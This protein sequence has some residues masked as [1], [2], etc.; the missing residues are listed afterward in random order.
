VSRYIAPAEGISQ[1]WIAVLEAMNAEAN[2]TATNVMVTI[3]SPNAVDV[4][5]VRQVLDEELRRRGQHEVATVANTL[6]PSTF[7]QPPAHDWQP[8]LPSTGIAELDDAADQLYAEYLDILPILRR[9]PANARGTYFSRMISWPGKT[10]TGTNQLKDRIEFLRK[11][12]TN[13]RATSNASD[14]VIAGDGEYPIDGMG[15]GIQEYAATDRRPQGFPCLVHIDVSVHN[16]ALSLTAV[17]RHWHLITRAYGNMVGL[18]RLQ[19]FLC[20]QTGF[21]VGELVVVA[22]YANAER[23]EYGGRSG[24]GSLLDRA[25]AVA[26]SPAPVVAA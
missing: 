8:G 7:Y 26:A 23:G 22:G 21:K 6:F 15:A 13:G 1:A 20:Q 11:E 16:G 17:Y 10:G 3:P 5:E 9:I 25:A 14:L 19:S 18:T 12:R 2:G 4:V 24:V